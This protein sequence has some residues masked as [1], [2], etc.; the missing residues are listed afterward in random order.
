MLKEKLLGKLK[1]MI[2]G[3]ECLLMILIKELV[4]EANLEN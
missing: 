2:F 4:K 1:L 3:K